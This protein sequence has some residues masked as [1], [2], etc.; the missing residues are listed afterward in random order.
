MTTHYFG[1]WGRCCFSLQHCCWLACGRNKS[2][3][4]ARQANAPQANARIG[5]DHGKQIDGMA[6]CSAVKTKPCTRALHC[7]IAAKSMRQ[8]RA[9]DALREGGLRSYK[10]QLAFGA[11]V[12]VMMGTFYAVGHVAGGAWRPLPAYVRP[13][14][15]LRVRLLCYEIIDRTF[16]SR[17]DRSASGLH[18]TYP[19]ALRTTRWDEV[20]I[21]CSTAWTHPCTSLK[22]PCVAV[23]EGG[24]RA[25][26]PDRGVA[27]G[28]AAAGDPDQRPAGV[29]HRSQAPEESTAPRPCAGKFAAPAT[30]EVAQQR[31]DWAY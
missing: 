7:L 30:A 15:P 10:D 14:P 18:P 31:A 29:A 13:D 26:R 16:I 28:N 22:S 27:R 23:A 4:A 21:I 20:L 6:A 1:I 12:L 24:W 17:V 5:P 19:G 3:S 9:A 8:E 11:H 2:A 25:D